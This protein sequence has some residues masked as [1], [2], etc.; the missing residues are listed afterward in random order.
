MVP[1]VLAD[2]MLALEERI[3]RLPAWGRAP[4]R[5]VLLVYSYVLLHGWFLVPLAL[6]L[7]GARLGWSG[8]VLVFW[9]LM[10]VGVAGFAGGVAW[11]LVHPPSRWLL[12]RFGRYPAWWAATTVYFV[13]L[14]PVLKARARSAEHPLDPADPRVALGIVLAAL[15][16]GSVMAWQF[17]DEPAAAVAADHGAPR[18]TRHRRRRKPSSF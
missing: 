16:A 5:A 2:W 9:V 17:H 7:A 13:V 12:G 6:V 3:D 18:K 4:F 1:Q 11:A 8:L 10:M 15:I 14:L